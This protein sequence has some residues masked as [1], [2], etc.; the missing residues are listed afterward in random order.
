MT[1][2][3]IY[4]A[5][6]PSRSV[7]HDIN[8]VDYHVLEWGNP[9]GPPLVLLHGW[10]DCGASFQ[11]MVD[12]LP[13]GTFVVAPDW[14][15]FGRTA[16]RT[17][18]YWFPDYLA[19]LHALL[20]IYSPDEPV[21]LLGHS[22]GANAAALYAGTFPERIRRFVNAE[23]FGLPD[24]DPA[25]APANYRRWIEKRQ[26][27]EVFS[28]FGS[29][30]DLAAVIRKRS[31][32]MPVDRARFV[33]RQWARLADDGRVELRADPAHKLPNA[34]LYRRQEAAA[35]WRAIEADVLLIMGER[36]AF[37]EAMADWRHEEPSARPFP[38]A[39]LVVVP[40]CGHMLHFEQPADLAR[41]VTA[42]TGAA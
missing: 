34:V 27:P 37:A 10:G 17:L 5:K 41:A 6:C 36:T 15:G 12:E 35:C 25:G 22:M 33:A 42:F 32:E 7:R 11:F 1:T 28:T 13:E 19:D 4:S 3:Q 40:D 9:A 2:S 18:G 30:D 29:F 23:G 39:D 20:S 38:G 16:S 24:S 31:P 21:D 8:G 14:R 26:D